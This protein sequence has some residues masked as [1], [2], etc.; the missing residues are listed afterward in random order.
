MADSRAKE[1]VGI[2]DRLFAKRQPL[3]SLWQEIGEN[4]YA[5]RA[6]F[7]REPQ[8]GEDYGADQYDSYPE[9]L[10][11]MLG[12]SVSA[13]LRPRDR[14]WFKTITGVDGIDRN[15]DNRRVLEEVTSR[16]RRR[17]YSV[18]SNFIGATKQ[19][20]HDFVTFGQA[21]ISVEEHEDRERMFM[22]PFHLGN[23]A[24]LEN[25]SL[26]VDHTHI[27]DKMTAR[28]MKRK[29]TEKALHATVRKACEK[30]PD[31]EFP[32]RIV[33]LPKAEYDYEKKSKRHSEQRDPRGD[34]RK[35]PFIAVYV[36]EQNNHVMS[37]SPR[38]LFPLV[39][40]RW[41][42]LS[43]SP[44]AFS[45]AT[46]IALP[47]SRLIQA[48]GRILLEAGEKAIDPPIA[49]EEGAVREANIAAGAMTWIAAEDRR[50][51]D[52]LMPL[53]IRY[54][55]QGGLALRQDIRQMLTQAFYID[56]LTL[57]PVDGA[58]MTAFEVGRRL[59][60]FVRQTLPLFEPMEVEYNSKL[61][62]SIYA[63]LEVLGEFSDLPLTPDLRATEIKWEFESPI[64]TA[65]NR[66]LVEKFAEAV[67]LHATGSEMGATS[68]LRLDVALH[69]AMKGT[70]APAAWL[71][72][73]EEAAAVA[74]KKAA[75][76]M[77][78]AAMQQL[79][80]GAAVAGQVGEAGQ[81]LRAGGVLPAEGEAP[82][83]LP[84]PPADPRLE[85]LQALYGE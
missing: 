72:S 79:Q 62:D 77:M 22:R 4:F 65:S 52:V 29:F 57:P 71:M 61:L 6:H 75:E 2:G 48:L 63:Q 33:I 58:K 11:R 54:D 67:R 43:G 17:M 20:D 34:A 39:I 83:A 41:L 36:D 56:K 68:R 7:T 28:Q 25:S 50:V 45:P 70:D 31:Q 13:M 16:M 14:P 27:K 37:E 15:I 42:R 66:M 49:A 64:Q 80:Q 51:Q 5:T 85:G 1:L 74:E 30:N 19:G 9:L 81:A 53:D 8:I 69:D 26:E 44:Y 3:A 82:L 47:D 18:S 38:L 73:D 10:R 46:T 55:L 76:Q 59:E 78:V 32:Y 40:P 12:D 35:M 60:E 21:V 23:V 24:W 84:P